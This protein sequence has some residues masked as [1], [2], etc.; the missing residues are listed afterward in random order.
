M[1]GTGVTRV[2]VVEDREPSSGALE[3]LLARDEDVE[4]V[5]ATADGEAAARAFARA[6]DR[7]DVA[8]VHR[9]RSSDAIATTRAIRA[10]APEARVVVVSATPDGSSVG[11]AIAAGA[12]GVLPRSGAD[13][14]VG[15][16]VR[17]AAAGELVLPEGDLVAV[18]ER[19]ERSRSTADERILERLTARETQILRSLASGAST[20]GIADELGISVLTVQTHLK[21]IL[22]KLGAHSKIEAV[23]VAWRLGLAAPPRPV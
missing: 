17:R 16:A 8:V 1:K 21:S 6:E 15:E 9:E 12:C 23:T 22:A 13:D 14:H 20:P 3:A 5:L 2:L 11:D 7:P 19:L 4:I 18:L 10:A